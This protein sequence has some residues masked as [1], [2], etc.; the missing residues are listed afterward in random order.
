MRKLTLTLT[1]CLAVC[2]VGVLVWRAHASAARAAST[3]APPVAT[4]WCGDCFDDPDVKKVVICHN[5]NTIEISC[6]AL[7]GHFEDPEG[8]IPRTDVPGHEDDHC[9][10]CSSGERAR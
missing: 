4:V 2:L 7:G 10:P 1:L 5:G 6:N 8:F 9:G 3:A